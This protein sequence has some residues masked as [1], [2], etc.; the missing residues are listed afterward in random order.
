MNKQLSS[1]LNYLN[2]L[3][4]EIVYKTSGKPFKSGNK[5]N[6]VKGIVVNQNTQLYGFV[7]E[8]DESIVDC[9]QAE[10]LD[11]TTL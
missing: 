2:S 5:F 10:I 1:D 9:H 7:F 3:I 11:Y 8:E 6:T 4:G